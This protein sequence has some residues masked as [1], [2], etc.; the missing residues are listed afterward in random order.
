VRATRRIDRALAALIF[1]LA[2]LLGGAV[3]IAQIHLYG[4][5][6]FSL[7][8]GLML[9]DFGFFWGGA[10]LFWLGNVSL[11]FQPDQFNA[12]LAQQ[13]APG[14]MQPYA[15]WS[16]PPS[17]LLPLLPFGL[18]SAQSAMVLW[19]TGTF[20]LLTLALR[21]W[22]KDWLLVLA[23]LLSPAAIYCL[24]FNQNGALTASLLIAGLWMVDRRPVIAG[25]CIGLLVIKPQLAILLPFA[26][27]AAGYWRAFAS[28]ALVAVVVFAATILLFGAD[29]WA[30]F[31]HRTAPVMSAQLLHDYGFLPHH[32][33]P[34]MFVTLRG[35]GASTRVASFGQGLSTLFA[36]AA[37]IWAW[38]QPH[39]DQQWRNA[40]TCSA[41]LLATPF[42]YV[43]DMIPV[44][45]AVALVAQTGFRRGF[46]W[47][48]RPIL[49]A[50]WAWP[51][52][53]VTWSLNLGLPPI[54]GFLLLAL[55]LSLMWRAA[56]NTGAWGGSMYGRL[57]RSEAS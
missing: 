19:I 26:L 17:M 46:A 50:M 47:P 25:A 51:A 27:A 38:R 18:L 2:L 56:R 57:S 54:G 55:A 36:I 49:A 45:L 8:S 44:M 11:V 4:P 5:H 30:G 15:T 7:P 28:A 52:I 6:F 1:T 12:W 31:L 41:V 40:L 21:H 29:A 32:A 53:T 3:Y 22:F 16:Y 14:S 37:V 42:G 23:V 39:I 33:M 24:R 48:E 10:R 9:R 13:I 20:G 34:T 35:W 43:Y